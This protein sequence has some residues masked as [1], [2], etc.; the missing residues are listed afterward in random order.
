M[1]SFLSGR[2]LGVGLLGPMV[3]VCFILQENAKLLSKS[4]VVAPIPPKDL[5]GRASVAPRPDQHLVLPVVSVLAIPVG[6]WSP[7]MIL[8]VLFSFGLHHFLVPKST[9]YE[10]G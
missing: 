2:L 6:L 5:W 1:S 4:V 10:K 7:L 9:F 3:S 8:I